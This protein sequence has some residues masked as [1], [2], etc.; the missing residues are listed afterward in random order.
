[1]VNFITAAAYR[2][3]LS[4]PAAFTQPGAPTLDISVHVS[5]CI[6]EAELAPAPVAVPSVRGSSVSSRCFQT[7]PEIRDD[8][9]D[10]R[11]TDGWGERATC[12][13]FPFLSFLPFSQ[14]VIHMPITPCPPPLVTHLSPT[15]IRMRRRK[16]NAKRFREGGTDTVSLAGDGINHVIEDRCTA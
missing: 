5:S 10:R 9:E 7:W 8:K 6:S 1:M 2:F 11:G 4:F 14:P 12:H 13:P 3:S 16:I 15:L